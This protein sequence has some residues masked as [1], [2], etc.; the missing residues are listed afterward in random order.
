VQPPA[1]ETLSIGDWKLA[2]VLEARVRGEYRHDLPDDDRGLLTERARIGADAARGP[3]E[4]RVVLQDVRTWDLTAGQPYILGPAFGPV[5]GVYEA[6]GEAHTDSVHPSFVRVGRQAVTWGEG[7]LLG[8]ADWSPAGR[9]LDAVRGRLVVGDGAFE[10]LAA[11]LSDPAQLGLSTY[12]ELLGARGEWAFDP[13][14]QVEVY[15]LVRY[16]QQN[17]DQSL[18]KTVLGSTYTAALR[19]HG[20]RDGWRYGV[21]GAYQVGR[22]HD[23]DEDRAAWA[24]A[25]HVAYELEHVLLT[26]ALRLGAAYASGDDGGSTYHQFDPLLPDVHVWHGAM[27]AFTWS[28]EIEGNARASIVPW[29]DAAAYVEYRYARLAQAGGAWRTDYL[30]TVGQA[31]ANTQEELGHEVDAWLTWRPWVPVELSAGYSVLVLGD[32]AKAV[33]AA[34]MPP[35][36]PS[37]AQFAWLQ[38]GVRVP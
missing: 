37:V 5:T 2:P 3:V 8:V 25:G 1:P 12:G 28:N 4:A 18:E 9:T 34:A 27:D 19:V 15:A 10:L 11:S 35:S 30:T 6:F 33:L 22:V 29:T 36:T 24:A 38:A 32:G 31:P 16:A 17:P 7:R 13:L 20:A 23:L 26:P 14:L 21:E